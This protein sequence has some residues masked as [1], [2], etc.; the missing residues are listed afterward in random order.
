MHE[1]M[2]QLLDE[3]PYL[4]L[5]MLQSRVNALDRD[6]TQGMLSA[7]KKAGTGAHGIYQWSP[8]LH[9]AELLTRY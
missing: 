2:E 9:E 8:E 1:C 6:A 3:A 4:L 7:A 5:K